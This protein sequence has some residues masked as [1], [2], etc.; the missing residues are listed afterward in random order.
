MAPGIGAFDS[1]V[2][3][4]LGLALVSVLLVTR[5]L[6]ARRVRTVRTVP[7][8]GCGGA[9]TPQ[10]EYTAT[11]FSKPIMMI[12][13]AIYRP[14]REVEALDKGSVYFPHA[15]RYRSHIEP[16]FERYLYQ[17]LGRA[18]LGLADRL[19]VL[20]AGS[21]HAY[22]AYV[23]VLVLILVLLVWWRA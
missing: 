15:V 11:A 4:T 14:T 6:M 1:V 8:W 5:S 7:T 20:Q 2:P 18:V 13:G 12:F 3:V 9:L 17:P 22:L 16:T 23:I 10:T 21:L 19:R